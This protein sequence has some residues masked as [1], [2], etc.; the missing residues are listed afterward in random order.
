[1]SFLQRPCLISLLWRVYS[2]KNMKMSL[3]APEETV[4]F[5]LLILTPNI[6]YQELVGFPYQRI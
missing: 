2:L 3:L 4:D 5:L 6:S 1:M